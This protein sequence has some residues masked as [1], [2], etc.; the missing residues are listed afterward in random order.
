MS[1]SKTLKV[2]RTDAEWR[3][4]L[5]AE[6][7][8]VARQ[9]GTERA[10]TPGNLNDEKR[11]GTYHCVGCGE[12]LWRS[13]HKFDSGTGWPSFFAP[14]D[15]AAVATKTDWKLVLPRTE[16]HCATCGSHMGHV[17]P[18]GPPPTR[19]RWCINGV[20]L[21]FQPDPEQG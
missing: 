8:R 5:T 18:D 4:M 11:A 21:R 13:D 9:E 17:F 12:P 2:T 19:Q 6:Q 15:E 3:D 10:F 20:V 14:I 16:V 7:Y 1:S